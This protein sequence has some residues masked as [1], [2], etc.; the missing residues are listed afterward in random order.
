MENLK[1]DLTLRTHGKTMKLVTALTAA[2]AV[3]LTRSADAADVKVDPCAVLAPG[4]I[5]SALG[6]APIAAGKRDNMGLVDECA[7]TMLDGGDLD[8]TFYTTPVGAPSISSKTARDKT[9]EAIAGLGSGAV[10]K[11][12]SNPPVIPVSEVVEVVTDQQH[13]DVH[14][15]N[16][17]AGTG[18]QNKDRLIAL[19][20]TILARLH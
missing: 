15:V 17:A 2:V 8:V 1:D 16:A 20:R 19:A 3:A 4:D 9:Y 6:A 18:G 11:D 12:N 10:Y 14:Y 5:Q 13:F 7:W